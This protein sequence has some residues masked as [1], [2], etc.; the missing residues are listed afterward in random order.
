MDGDPRPR[1]PPQ[2]PPFPEILHIGSM[3]DDLSPGRGLQDVLPPFRDEAPSA[4]DDG[5][6]AVE[7]EKLSDDIDDNHPLPL[8]AAAGPDLRH[9]DAVG[10]SGL[11]DQ[12]RTGRPPFDMA[13]NEDQLEAG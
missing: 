1:P 7:F 4:K 11:T 12:F 3:E 6:K 2:H 5:G 10:K 13:G 8:A 9:R